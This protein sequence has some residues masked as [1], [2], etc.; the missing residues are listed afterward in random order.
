MDH[1]A[2]LWETLSFNQHCT[3]SKGGYGS[4]ANIQLSSKNLDCQSNG[5]FNTEENFVN[6]FKDVNSSII[7]ID[8]N[9]P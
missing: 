8:F 9:Q 6:L 2:A 3:G 5:G 1:L 4:A 7:S